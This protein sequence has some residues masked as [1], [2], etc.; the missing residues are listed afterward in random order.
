MKVKNI[1]LIFVNFYKD[2]KDWMK[3]KDVFFVAT[4]AMRLPSMIFP[5]NVEM[6][7]PEL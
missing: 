7:L 6:Q 2:K 3:T 1:I 4:F 5:S